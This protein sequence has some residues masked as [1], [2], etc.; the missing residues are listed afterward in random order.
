M[1]TLQLPSMPADFGIK[2]T[3]W[4]NSDC[5]EQIDAYWKAVGIWAN[6]CA[7]VQPAA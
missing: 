7:R 4:G 5:K 3:D 1:E 2:P 6:V